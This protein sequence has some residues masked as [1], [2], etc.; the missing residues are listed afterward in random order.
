MKKASALAVLDYKDIP[1]G[2]FA[3]DAI[4]KKA[5][6]AFLRAGTTTRGRYLVLFGGSTASTSES[7]EEA[8]AT[9]GSSVLDSTLLPDVHPALFDSVFGAKRKAN[10]SLLVLET[11]TAASIV[12]AVEAAM[13]GTPVTLVE[14][15]LSDTGLAGKGVAVLS[16]VLHD[17]EAAA[18]LAS[19]GAGVNS[20]APRGLSYRL[21]AAPH[22]VLERDVVSSTRFDSA[23]LLELDGEAG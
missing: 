20:A 1:A 8:L 17:I 6:I 13:K 15:R 14:V 10:G 18:A 21:I 16:G 23:P 5:P 22:D 9:T 7:L 3:V 4:L 12:R 2:V 11:E 19:T